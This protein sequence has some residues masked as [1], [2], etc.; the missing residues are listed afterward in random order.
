MAHPCRRSALAAPSTTPSARSPSPEGEEPGKVR[1]MPAPERNLTGV[2]TGIYT[3]PDGSSVSFTATLLH[4]GAHLSGGVHEPD[5]FGGSGGAL[6]ASISGRAEGGS[7][8]FRK[9]YETVAAG[10]TSAVDYSG[11][12]S[13]DGNEIEGGWRIP[14]WFGPV[15]GTFLMIRN[16]GA[17]VP[18]GKEQAA[19][20]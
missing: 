6:H 3:Y 20:A 12:L 1:P 10:F 15:A 17:D 4:S 13:A 14:G 8:T 2:W 19:D 9:Q 5:S 7:V 16:E 18:A 11:A